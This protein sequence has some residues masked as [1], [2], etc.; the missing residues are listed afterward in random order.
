M[1]D[2]GQ[3][4]LLILAETLHGRNDEGRLATAALFRLA[5]AISGCAFL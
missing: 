1:G 3:E 4:E 5:T 2:F